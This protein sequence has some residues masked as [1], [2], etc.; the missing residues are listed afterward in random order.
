M[1]DHLSDEAF[2]ILYAVKERRLYR[3]KRGRFAIDGEEPPDRRTREQLRRQGFI[4]PVYGND[5]YRI[6]AT[7]DAALGSGIRARVGAFNDRV[8]Q[9]EAG[10]LTFPEAFD[11]A[12]EERRRVES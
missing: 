5:G 4:V 1:Q 10:G 7:G 12:I 6:T 3:D 9:L 8:R 11:R 2:R